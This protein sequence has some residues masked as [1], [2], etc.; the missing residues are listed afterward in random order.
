MINKTIRA[1]KRFGQNFL[2]DQN[3]IS[4]IIK[5]AKPS[6]KE[7][8]EIGPGQGAITTYLLGSAK[9]VTAYEIDKDMVSILN[10]KISAPHFEL[11]QGDFL[12]AKFEWEGKKDVVANLP[13]YITTDILF[14][15]FDSIEKFSKLTIM[16]QDEVAERIIA[17]KNT[18]QYGKLSVSCQFLANVKKIIKI[19]PESFYPQPRVNSAVV[20]LEFKENIDKEFMNFFLEFI[21]ACFFMKRKKLENNLKVFM[22]KD[23]IKEIY[24]KLN[25]KPNVRPQEL[26]LEEFLEIFKMWRER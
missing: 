25:L 12:E 10:K 8:I 6:G 5:T 18:P 3:V 7:I 20:V 21:K 4:T 26:D 16:V 14:K 9:K 15:I 1:K 17:K 11:I 23:Q 24:S 22:S 19:L 2:I 13:Y